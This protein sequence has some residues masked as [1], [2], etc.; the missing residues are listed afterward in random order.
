MDCGGQDIVQAA[1]G[2]SSK[3]ALEGEGH[4]KVSTVPSSVVPVL[5]VNKL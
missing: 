3:Y 2:E 4:G 1:E 5:S